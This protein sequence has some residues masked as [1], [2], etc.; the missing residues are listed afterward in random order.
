MKYKNVFKIICIIL[1]IVSAALLFSPLF[2][3]GYDA[4]PFFVLGFVI[5]TV[6]VVFLLSTKKTEDEKRNSEI[7]QKNY[8]V[9]YKRCPYCAEDVKKE[10]IVC[11]HCGRDLKK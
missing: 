7:S 1:C 4:I 2:I 8:W 3:K 11:K 9:I 5:F 6:T 10:A